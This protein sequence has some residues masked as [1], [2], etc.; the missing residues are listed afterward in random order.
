MINADQLPES[1][2]L[3]LLNNNLKHLILFGDNNPLNFYSNEIGKKEKYHT[4]LYNR[5]L[6]VKGSNKFSIDRNIP[7]IKKESDEVCGA[8]LRCEHNCKNKKELYTS[9]A[10]KSVIESYYADIY[11][12][13][14]VV[15]N[16]I[17]SIIALK[18]GII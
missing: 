14:Y 5:L 18:K 12:F 17:V 3:P 4:T 8:V 11:V 2:L 9:H 10:K 1:Y 6:T 16:V 13:I 15:K 7:F